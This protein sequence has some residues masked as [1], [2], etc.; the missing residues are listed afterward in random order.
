VRALGGDIWGSVGVGEMEGEEKEQR[1]TMPVAR[2]NRFIMP[3]EFI[4]PFEEPQC[5]AHFRTQPSDYCLHTPQRPFFFKKKN[6]PNVCALISFI[7]I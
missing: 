3:V 1:S 2:L 6:V 4:L 7:S 5:S